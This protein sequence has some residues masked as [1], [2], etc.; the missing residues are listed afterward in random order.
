[1]TEGMGVL[2]ARRRQ[3]GIGHLR[4]CTSP[5]KAVS[6]HPPKRKGRFAARLWTKVGLLAPRS[7]S[8]ASPL[9]SFARFRV[10]L[11]PPAAAPRSRSSK[12]RFLGAGE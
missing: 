4:V 12:G 11:A 3:A 6:P 1:M 10:A 5:A 7:R 9:R 8:F 2:L